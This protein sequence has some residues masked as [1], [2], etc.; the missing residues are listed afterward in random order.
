MMTTE[1]NRVVECWKLFLNC[2]YLTLAQRIISRSDRVDTFQCLRSGSFGLYKPVKSQPV[3]N[4][5][6]EAV[7][8]SLSLPGE[9]T[10]EEHL[11]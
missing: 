3:R 11:L 5:K 7:W 8:K 4:A 9:W 10:I 6:R 1:M 2:P